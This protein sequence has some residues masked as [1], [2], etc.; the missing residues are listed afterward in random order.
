MQLAVAC[1]RQRSASVFCSSS[2]AC[3]L[4]V[5]CFQQLAQF[6]SACF[7]A[8]AVSHVCQGCSWQLFVIGS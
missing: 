5:A 2:D 3:V 8:V 6:C 7:S 4:R 1:P